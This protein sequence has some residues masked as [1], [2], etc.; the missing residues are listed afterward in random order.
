V[1]SQFPSIANAISAATTGSEI[2]VAP[3]TY[4]EWLPLIDKDILIRSSEGAELTIIQP[5][6]GG[7]V[8]TTSPNTGSITLQGFTIQGGAA[9]M[10]SGLLLDDCD[11]T[12]VDCVFQNNTLSFEG[13]AI[14]II[15]GGS[16]T[17]TGS[18]VKTNSA[19]FGG[20]IYS[21]QSSLYLSDCTFDANTSG[22]GSGIAI[23]GPGSCV[24]ENT[25]FENGTSIEP[26][27]N[28]GGAIWCT[29]ATPL[30]RNCLFAYNDGAWGGAIYIESGNPIIVDC[31]FISNV[32]EQSYGYGGAI[33]I[34]EGNPEIRFSSFLGNTS[35]SGGG[36]IYSKSDSVLLL[37]NTFEMNTSQSGGAIELFESQTS[38]IGCWFNNNDAVIGGSIYIDGTAWI[39][40][41]NF[42]GNTAFGSGQWSRGGAIYVGMLSNCNLS[43]C[44][45]QFN[46]AQI[47][48]GAI[49]ISE[50][51]STLT[52]DWSTFCSNQP[53]HITG[54]WEDAGNN[55]LCS[56]CT[57]DFDGDAEVNIHDLLV[58]LAAWGTPE[59]DLDGDGTGNL[60]DLLILINAWGVCP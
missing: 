20:G 1:P 55:S 29:N 26:G 51:S 37:G 16:L 13:G 47:E 5:L 24:I 18:L 42:V 32:S 52:V 44:D 58:F 19:N 43:A 17:M 50:F 60:A 25:I 9:D 7:R 38:V 2:V 10:G 11:M 35:L 41:S 30:I 46:S 56:V 22:F 31:D 54:I 8:L 57:G 12:I 27:V 33:Y 34:E 14:A 59:S 15:N 23:I 40:S 49:S 53:N 3:G 4:N 21:N 36:A 28:S 6:L 39:S 45:F 48:G